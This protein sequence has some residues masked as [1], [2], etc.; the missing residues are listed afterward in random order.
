MPNPNNSE[1]SSKMD[2]NSLE[3]AAD[4]GKAE[5]REEIKG[6]LRAAKSFGKAENRERNKAG[7]SQ[8]RPRSSGSQ[9]QSPV[10]RKVWDFSIDYPAVPPSVKYPLFDGTTIGSDVFR[11]RILQ[12][13]P[14]GLVSIGANFNLATNTGIQF[15]AAANLEIQNT[16]TLGTF[17]TQLYSQIVRNYQSK[18][19]RMIR[20]TILTTPG[21]TTT[22]NG[23]ITRWITVYSSIYLTYRGLEGFLAL[24][25]FNSF[26][27]AI[28]GV[29]DQFRWRLVE[30][31]R[32]LFAYKVPA[33]WN[34]ML[35][36]L[37]GPKID[38]VTGVWY[39][40]QFGLNTGSFDLTNST[41]IESIFIGAE[42]AL[43]TLAFPNDPAF[44]DDFQRI[45]N[46]FSLAYGSEPMPSAKTTSHN[47]VEVALQKTQAITYF[48]TTGGPNLALT[49]PNLNANLGFVQQLPIMVPYSGTGVE[50][51]FTLLRPT[52]CSIDPV[53]GVDGTTTFASAIG[54]ISNQNL[55]VD[56]FLYTLYTN[57][58][59]TAPAI[60]QITRTN[61]NEIILSDPDGNWWWSG[62]S[63]N[64][65][66]NYV[67]ARDYYGWHLVYV[68]Y[69]QV[70][71][72]TIRW[73]E[74]M[75]MGPVR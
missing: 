37:C 6:N 51:L 62:V 56:G 40:N 11:D 43:S 36:T 53:A 16:A 28:S 67:D 1:K 41:V 45:A 13:R 58:P 3:T 50:Q 59:G 12:Q 20:D 72:Q 65:G 71:E 73:L 22:V 70:I 27:S 19:G 60:K 14:Q 38:D 32:R 66:T 64:G 25:N 48:D 7:H 39:A 49:W 10:G 21:N 61:L 9:L 29:I 46:V 35:D 42:A 75:F 63:M 74:Q 47:L 68:Q 18:I 24:S 17:F 44:N 31:E 8:S 34:T 69:N 30:G 23:A 26:S 4:L 54:L 15:P 5:V 2:K 33:A 52:L 55:S 57:D